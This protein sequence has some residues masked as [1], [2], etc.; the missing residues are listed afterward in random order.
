MKNI[1]TTTVYQNLKDQTDLLHQKFAAMA[2][3]K[4]QM[5][6][7]LVQN[8]REFKEMQYMINQLR[9]K[10]ENEAM[11]GDEWRLEFEGETKRNNLLV[12]ENETRKKE[13]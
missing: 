5:G 4:E 9:V 13:N 11:I 2:E 8:E 12:A 3:V 10:L 1:S 6:E 7:R